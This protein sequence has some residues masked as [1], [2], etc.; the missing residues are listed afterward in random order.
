MEKH[1]TL[2]KQTPPV[3]LQKPGAGLPLLE[4]LVVRFI[5]G[6]II[7]KRSLPDDNIK[8][9]QIFTDKILKITKNLD[10]QQLETRILVPKLQGLEDSSRFWS[11]SMTLE[12]LLIV[13]KNMKFIITEL[14]HNRVPPLKVD[15]AKV[16]P[17]GETSSKEVL[18][19][20]ETFFKNLPQELNSQI[21]DIRCSATLFHP[22]FG[23]SKALQWHWL[24]GTHQGIHY[25]Q[26]K[27]ILR[28]LDLKSNIN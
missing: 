10:T 15:I 24:L 20:F 25:N 17:L 13:A 16:K 28:A 5:Y 2:Q 14:S 3:Q 6:Y 1:N 7:S 19:E 22:W 9:L 27:H 8:T 21:G 11:V 18:A 4:A 26:I 23:E 12:H